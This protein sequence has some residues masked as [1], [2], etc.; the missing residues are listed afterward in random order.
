MANVKKLVSVPFYP[1]PLSSRVE[2]VE[3]SNPVREMEI[4]TKDGKKGVVTALIDSGSFYT[5]IRKDCVPRGA[6]IIRYKKSEKM[7][8]AGKS[9]GIH[10]VAGMDLVVMVEGHPIEDTVRISPDLKREFILG[11]GTMQKWDITIKNKN[12]HTTIHVGHDMN[13]PDIQTVE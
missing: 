3:M 9:G 8:T 1:F 11:A 12:G 4:R 7:A 6:T 2:A 5:L 13:D 10:A